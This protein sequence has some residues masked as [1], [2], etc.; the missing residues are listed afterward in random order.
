MIRGT[1]NGLVLNTDEKLNC[2]DLISFAL[3]Q[4][5]AGSHGHCW[6]SGGI[7]RTWEVTNCRHYLTELA[8]YWIL[9]SFL[10]V[11]RIELETDLGALW[12]SL[13]FGAQI[14]VGVIYLSGEK[15]LHR[16]FALLKSHH[17]WQLLSINAD[18]S[19][20][21]NWL[22]DMT[23]VANLKINYEKRKTPRQLLV[24]Q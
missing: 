11:I 9:Y 1:R 18:K 10:T 19:S 21:N 3:P 13:V 6:A 2:W 20:S 17:C 14:G 24:T 4:G 12:G 8:L 22:H 15:V 23:T 16:A 7:A 5:L